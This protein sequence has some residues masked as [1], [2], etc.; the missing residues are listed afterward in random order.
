MK[1]LL[2]KPEMIVAAAFRE[3]HG[4]LHIIPRDTLPMDVW[5]YRLKHDAG[6]QA[7]VSMEL[8]FVTSHGQVCTAEEARKVAL[9]AGQLDETKF[10]DKL[11]T[12]DEW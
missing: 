12:G 7:N 9:I 10:K 4:G 11:T 6:W 2:N 8:F 3:R 1:T 5:N